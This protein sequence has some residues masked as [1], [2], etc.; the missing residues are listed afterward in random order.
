MLNLIINIDLKTML[1]DLFLPVR[2]IISRNFNSLWICW[3]DTKFHIG[4]KDI[5]SRPS[6]SAGRFS[7]HCLTTATQ[8]YHVGAR[9]FSVQHPLARLPLFLLFIKPISTWMQKSYSLSRHHSFKIHFLL[10]CNNIYWPYTYMC[11]PR[12]ME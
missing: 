1:S 7:G 2:I 9:D 12:L 10:W 6:Y 11:I 4:E 3:T 5:N 8:G